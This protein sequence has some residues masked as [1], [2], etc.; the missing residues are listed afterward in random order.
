M[1]AS[2]GL[3]EMLCEDVQRSS[4]EGKVVLLRR[5]R[6]CSVTTYQT[7]SAPKAKAVGSCSVMTYQKVVA[8]RSIRIGLINMH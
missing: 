3:N 8:F 2:F 6:S 4:A 7:W 5:I 1:L